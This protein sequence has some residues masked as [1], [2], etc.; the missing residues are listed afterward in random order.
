MMI[1]SM[2]LSMVLCGVTSGFSEK[3]H[4]SVPNRDLQVVGKNIGGF[5]ITTDLGL[6]GAIAQ[7]IADEREA[8][9]LGVS[10]KVAAESI[11]ENGKNSFKEPDPQL[12][13]DPAKLRTIQGFNNKNKLILTPSYNLAVGAGA[14]ADYCGALIVDQFK[15][16]GEAKIDSRPVLSVSTHKLTYTANINP[17]S[18]S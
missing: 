6:R 17:Y 9:A 10:G 1:L 3:R 11:Y 13:E 5:I 4:L 7:D 2:V 8:M 16:F 12:R 18:Q 14:M 15:L